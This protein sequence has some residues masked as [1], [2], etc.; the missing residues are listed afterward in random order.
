VSSGIP[1]WSIETLTVTGNESKREYDWEEPPPPLPPPPHPA[2]AKVTAAAAMIDFF[3]GGESYGQ[4]GCCRRD[5]WFS[6]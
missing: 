2:T 3:I 4:G 1:I 5:K 6:S